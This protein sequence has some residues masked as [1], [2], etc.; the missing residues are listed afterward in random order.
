MRAR[1][2]LLCALALAGCK[3]TKVYTAEEI[4][5]NPAIF[6]ELEKTCARDSLA[7]SNQSNCK[8]FEQA[9]HIKQSQSLREYF[10]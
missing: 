5:N 4:L 10:K 2:I 7:E 3:E 8:N 6:Q 1:F 9:K